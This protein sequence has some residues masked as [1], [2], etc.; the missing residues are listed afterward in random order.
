MKKFLAM[1]LLVGML[2]S[3]ASA[4]LLHAEEVQ[5]ATVYL[6][7][8][9]SAIAPCYNN[10]RSVLP[11]FS[12]SSTG[13]AKLTAVFVGISGVTT[14]VSSEM[15]IQKKALGGL[16]WTKVDIGTTSN[17]WTDSSTNI[18]G[19]FTHS[20]QLSKT[21]TYRAVITIYFYGSG[22]STDSVP[23]KIDRTYS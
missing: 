5:S 11:S 3:I 14:K 17:V 8:N 2:F 9:E 15:Y 22:G 4:P 19:S 12:I 18:S 7:L 6:D 21:G 1:L 13:L 23:T 20:F 16:L 10:G